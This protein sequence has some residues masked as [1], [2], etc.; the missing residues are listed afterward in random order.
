[1]T[2][3]KNKGTAKSM[4]QKLEEFKGLLLGEEGLLSERMNMTGD[5][6]PSPGLEE[7]RQRILIPYS[8][9]EW[10]KT[11]KCSERSRLHP[12]S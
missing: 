9:R 2:R 5:R 6:P 1:V 7:R 3:G 11:G 8:D 10:K 12:E 4:T